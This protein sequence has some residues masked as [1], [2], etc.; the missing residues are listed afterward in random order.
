MSETPYGIVGDG[1]MASHLARYLDLCGLTY[2][3]W[4]RRRARETGQTLADVVGPCRTVLLLID[5]SAIAPFASE[6]FELSE[7]NLVH[8]SGCVTTPRAQGMHPLCTFDTG[9]Y[10]LET[11]RAIPFV[12]EPEPHAF[13]DLFP[14]LP[15][16]SYVLDVGL[17][18]LYH[19]VSVMGGP[20]TTLLWNKLH[21]V[22]EERLGLPREVAGPYMT[23]VFDNLHVAPEAARTGPLTRADVETIRSNLEALEG[24]PFAGVYRAFVQATTP[25]LIAEFK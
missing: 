25:E 24:D 4:S 19:A 15:N 8:F 9:K 22:F 3:Q 16:P 21:Q 5:D 6:Q 11:Y 10:D 7:K 23:R 20:F 18:P 1:R 17:K 12:C 13:P 2:R 14:E